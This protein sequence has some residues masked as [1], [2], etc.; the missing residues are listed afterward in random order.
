MIPSIKTI[1]ELKRNINLGPGYG[2]Y[3]EILKA[4]NIP[5]KDWKAI[6]NFS[7]KKYTRNCISSC[8]EYELLLMCWNKDQHSPIH[9]YHF[10]ESWLKV[11]KGKLTIDVY[12][13]NKE[14]MRTVRT[15]S[16]TIG[17]GEYIYLND[18]MGYHSIRNSGNDSTTSLHLNID[19]VKEWEVFNEDSKTINKVTPSYDSA[20]ADCDY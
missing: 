7:D 12:Q 2:G 18:N 8:D 19:R 9:S 4:I 5:F 3:T 17:E 15:G 11:L 6:C 10:Q 14:D 16:I 13:I 20:T 1:S